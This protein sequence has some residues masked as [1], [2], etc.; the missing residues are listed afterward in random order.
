MGVCSCKDAKVESL[1]NLEVDKLVKRNESY[2]PDK[3]YLKVMSIK[4]QHPENFQT[5]TK[6]SELLEDKVYE[7]QVIIDIQELSNKPIIEHKINDLEEGAIMKALYN[8]FLFKEMNEEI[9]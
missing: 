4:C 6:V 7:G 8:H 2:S 9:L 3:K 5:Y 1:V